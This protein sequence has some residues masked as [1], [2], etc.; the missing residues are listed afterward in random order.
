[1]GTW[2]KARSINIYPSREWEWLWAPYVQQ[3]YQRVLDCLSP[4]DIVLEIGAGDLRLARLIAPRVRLVYALERQVAIAGRQKSDLP[5]NCRLILGDA[6]FI[7]FPQDISA[8]VL[9]MRHCTHFHLYWDKLAATNCRQ[10]ITNARWGLDVEAIDLS[11]DRYPFIDLMMGWYACNC[12]HTGFLPGPA[13]QLSGAM[14]DTIWEVKECPVC[15]RS[16][17]KHLITK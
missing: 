6:R 17:N 15:I 14:V 2:S 10:L 12:G 7:S 3:I 16:L 9:L 13:N 5:A 11:T 8:A 4:D 1:M